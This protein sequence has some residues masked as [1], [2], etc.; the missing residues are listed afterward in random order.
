[1]S[2]CHPTNLKQKWRQ[3]FQ[4]ITVGAL[5]VLMASCAS[6]QLVS[7]NGQVQTNKSSKN[8]GVLSQ[9]DPFES[10][11]RKAYEFNE[12]LDNIALKPVA[13]AYKKYTPDLFRTG[14]SN[15]F[16]NLSSVWTVINNILQGHGQAAAEGVIRVGVNTIFG[17]VGVFD[18]AS[19]MNIERHKAD[20][21]Q[22]LGRWGVPP[23]P[24]LVIPVLGPSTLRDSLAS[25][26]IA[27]GDLVWQLEQVSLR[28]SLYAFRA[29]DQRANLL[30]ATNMLDDSALDKYTFSR[31]IFLQLRMNE[32]E[33][34]LGHSLS[35]DEYLE[36]LPLQT[37]TN[38]LPAPQQTPNTQTQ[39]IKTLQNQ[40]DVKTEVLM[41]SLSATENIIQELGVDQKGPQLELVTTISLSQEDSLSQH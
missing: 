18:I 28:N 25:T 39:E 17:F 6:T 31:D 10:F 38:E 33:Q 9:V 12:N 40:T 41:P 20:F 7:D 3:A 21:G 14:V 24:Y 37:P 15:F 26:V 16:F 35:G 30:N 22:T 1:M 2:L 36:D 8:F 19:E 34:A 32:V 13:Q 5:V 23:G 27:K 29:I 4:G 11:N